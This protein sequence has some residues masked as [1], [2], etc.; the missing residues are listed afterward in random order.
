MPYW[1]STEDVVSLKNQLETRIPFLDQ[2]IVFRSN[3]QDLSKV[4]SNGLNKFHLRKAYNDLPSHVIKLKKKFPR[5][6][7]TSN[8]VY[9][10]KSREVIYIPALKCI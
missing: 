4:Y 9:F 8:L 5:P 7:N 6:A 3:Y 2:R 1:L 10:Q